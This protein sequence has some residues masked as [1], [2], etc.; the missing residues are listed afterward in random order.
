M[1]VKIAFFCAGI[2]LFSK[3]INSKILSY[4]KKDVSLKTYNS[5]GIDVNADM[6][7]FINDI[8]ELNEIFELVYANNNPWLI[9][10]GG[11]NVLFTG[12]YNGIVIKTLIKG[13][14]VIEKTEKHIFIRVYAGEDWDELVK[15]CVNNNWGGLENLSYI[16]GNAGTSPIQNIGAYGSELEEYFYSL[17]AMEVNTGIIRQFKKE[18]CD[19][20]YRTSIFKTDLKRKYVICSIV[21]KLDLDHKIKKNYKAI[22]EQLIKNKIESPTINDIRQAVIQVRKSKLPDPKVLGNAGSFF[23][24]PVLSKKDYEKLKNKFPNV[25]SFEG[26]DDCMKISAGWLIEQAGWRNFRKGDAGVYDKQALVLINYGNA[27][28]KEI[29]ELADMIK[30]SV[31]DKFDIEL[32]PEVDIIEV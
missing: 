20:G 21:L 8:Y 15:F 32:K 26:K 17:E 23:K 18:Q 28:G 6:I 9:L 7:C 11:N 1:Y 12:D 16:P 25:V 10:G 13:I 27:T 29:L 19:F 31:Y 24:N 30:D 3:F 2:I 5:F 4:K 22:S 14:R